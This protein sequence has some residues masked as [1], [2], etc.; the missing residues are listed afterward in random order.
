MKNEKKI[1][2]PTLCVLTISMNL[3]KICSNYDQEVQ[4]GPAQGAINLTFIVCPSA[5]LSIGP[6]VTRYY[7]VRVGLKPCH[8]KMKFKITR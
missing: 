1:I 5:V 4:M 8:A 2:M 6:L 3:Y 7:F